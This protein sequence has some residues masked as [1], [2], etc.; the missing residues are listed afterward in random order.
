MAAGTTSEA[1][2]TPTLA[3][4]PQL[5]EELQ[6]MTGHHPRAPFPTLGMVDAGNQQGLE[7][8]L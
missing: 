4:A 1:S 7:V 8:L 5:L 6:L 3:L 2:T